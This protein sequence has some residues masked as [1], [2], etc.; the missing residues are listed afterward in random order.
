MA[1]R[2]LSARRLARRLHQ[3]RRGDRDR[4]RSNYRNK[5]MRMTITILL[6]AAVL[7]AAHL[8]ERRYRV[9]VKKA[10]RKLYLYQLDNGSERLMKTYRIVLG[11]NPTGAKRKQGDGATPEGE[12]YITHKNQRSKFYLSLGLSYPN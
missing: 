5:A 3:K 12:Y 9:L 7:C 2:K 11:N 6:M 4:N 10:E 1:V 8:P